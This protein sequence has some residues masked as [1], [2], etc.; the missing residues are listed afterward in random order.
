MDEA[1]VHVA[2]GLSVLAALIGL[3]AV[4]SA[5][6]LRV[7]VPVALDLLLAAGLLRLT[8]A[9]TWALIG[10]A[11]AVVLVRKLVVV[12]LRA[13]ALPRSLTRSP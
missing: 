4:T 12:G 8:V 9:D 10:G 3:A 7:G 13:H 2:S 5:R 1:V 6:S 11:A